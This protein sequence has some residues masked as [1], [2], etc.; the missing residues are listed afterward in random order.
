MCGDDKWAGTGQGGTMGVG[1]AGSHM[2]QACSCTR[3]RKRVQRGV[4]RTAVHAGWCSHRRARARGWALCGCACRWSAWGR[5]R[6][7]ARRVVYA[8]GQARAC[9]WRMWAGKIAPSCYEG[10]ERDESCR[11][12]VEIMHARWQRQTSGGR[13]WSCTWGGAGGWAARVGARRMGHAG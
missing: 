2:S 11:W 1:R 3:G 5:T 13:A 4:C 7:G 6:V 12:V 9:R 8:G 10:C